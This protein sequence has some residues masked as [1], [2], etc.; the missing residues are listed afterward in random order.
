MNPVSTVW[1]G[2]IPKIITEKVIRKIFN[3]ES[4]SIIKNNHIFYKNRRKNQ[5]YSNLS[6]SQTQKRICIY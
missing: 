2:R 5:K 3:S 4:K 6:E 1:M